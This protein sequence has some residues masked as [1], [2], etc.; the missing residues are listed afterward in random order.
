[1]NAPAPAQSRAGLIAVLVGL[2]VAIVATVV[3]VVGRDDSDEK[4]FRPKNFDDEAEEETPTA[5]HPS[6][7]YEPGQPANTRAAPAP[8]P[9]AA[10]GTVEARGGSGEATELMVLARRIETTDPKRSRDLLRQALAL[11]P[12]D[13]T[14][15][16]A[17]SKKLF[18]DENHTE[19]KALVDRCLGANP[20][21]EG[22]KALA[23][24]M[25]DQTTRDAA[26]AKARACVNATPENAE[27]IAV[28]TDG[29]FYDGNKSAAALFALRQ[30]NVAPTA[31]ATTLALGRVKASDGNY[32]EARELFDKSCAAGNQSACYRAG[33]LRGEG[34]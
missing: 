19:A 14:A 22:C 9:V 17:L 2:I 10:P 18:L 12:T 3:V 31:P 28:L 24:Q 23:S 26:Q 5:A 7:T 32:R 21:S 6:R 29:A 16:D 25:Q 4:K 1:M 20:N 11:N 34:W 15:L 27:C 30:F 13:A 8:P 33:V